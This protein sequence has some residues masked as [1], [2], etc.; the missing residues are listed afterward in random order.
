MRLANLERFGQTLPQVDMRIITP[1]NIEALASVS[2]QEFLE[3]P[4]ENRLQYLTVGNITS[5]Q[6]KSGAVKNFECT[7]TFS[8][9]VNRE[10][11]FNT[12]LAQLLPDEI[13]TIQIGQ[14]TY[15]RK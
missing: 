1:E 15:E 3:L 2:H 9:E 13:R 12:S 14:E 11:Y 4:R 8:E 10:L 6:I 5:E 7:F